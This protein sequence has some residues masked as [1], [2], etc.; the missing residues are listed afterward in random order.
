ME[1]IDAA[2]SGNMVLLLAVIVVILGGL[3]S[4]LGVVIFREMKARIARAESLTDA[5]V[6]AFDDLGPATK[7][8]ADV[9]QAA[10]DELRRRRGGG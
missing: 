3:V 5:M 8:S 6:E 4:V 2:T 1:I 9:A 7:H 10:L